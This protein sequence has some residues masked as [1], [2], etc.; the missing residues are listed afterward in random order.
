M[1]YNV[2]GAELQGGIPQLVGSAESAERVGAGTSTVLH[3]WRC[4]YDDFPEPVAKLKSARVWAWPNVEAWAGAT[5]R[6]E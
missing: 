3:D 5:G 6:L 4:R 2:V 1:Q